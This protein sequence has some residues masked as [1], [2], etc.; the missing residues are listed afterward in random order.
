[1]TNKLQ[2]QTAELQDIK[3]AVA[4]AESVKLEEI[5]NEHRKCVEEVAT[6]QQF[7]TGAFSSQYDS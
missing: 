5:D 6:L 7:M 3:T 2:Q 1:L 4:V